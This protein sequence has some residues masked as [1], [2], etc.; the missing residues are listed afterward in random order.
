[1][2]A[3]G[4][5]PA[6]YWFKTGEGN[7]GVLQILGFTVG[8]PRGVR[9][10][11]KMLQDASRADGLARREKS[12]NMLHQLAVALWVYADDHDLKM[13]AGLNELRPY[14]KSDAVFRWAVDNVQYI[15]QGTR[16]PDPDVPTAY[17]KTMI[18]TGEGTN[19]LFSD[20]HVGFLTPEELEEL[21]IP[22]GKEPET[23]AI[24]E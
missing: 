19:V 3:K 1:M 12:R 2:F 8:E 20:A 9:I 16:T 5:L 6:T 24:L 15:N 18:Q 14:I 22:G 7:M 10:R 4:D 23:E 11:Y 21:G 13:P 17:D